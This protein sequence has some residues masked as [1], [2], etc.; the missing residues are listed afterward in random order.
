MMA[1][2]PA[3]FTN[4]DNPQT[5]N[6]QIFIVN[7]GEKPSSFSTVSTLTGISNPGNDWLKEGQFE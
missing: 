5:Q 6:A 1:V 4:F 7:A 2:F 3:I